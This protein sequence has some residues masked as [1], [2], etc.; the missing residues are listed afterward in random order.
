NL[1]VTQTKEDLVAENVVIEDYLD[2]D[3]VDLDAGSITIL[4]N[5]GLEIKEADITTDGA[6]FRIETH[7]NL[8]YGENMTVQYKVVM[9]QPTL[10]GHEVKNTATVSADNAEKNKDDNTVIITGCPSDPCPDPDNPCPDDPCPDDPCP[11]NPDNP[12]TPDDPD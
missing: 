1:V 5:E 4:D 10:V 11:D 7:R 9:T 3:D 6:H 8:A 12:D 2:R